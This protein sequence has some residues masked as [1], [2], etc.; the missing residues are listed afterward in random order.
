MCGNEVHIK[1]DSGA[2]LMFHRDSLNNLVNSY[3]MDLIQHTTQVSTL[4]LN[5]PV[6]IN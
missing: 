4:L 1:E 3:T 2:S 6:L 5:G